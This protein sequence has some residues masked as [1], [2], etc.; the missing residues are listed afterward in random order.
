MI[1]DRYIY[2]YIYNLP[3]LLNTRSFLDNTNQRGIKETKKKKR[4]KKGI[5]SLLIGKK[6][7]KRRVRDT[8]LR[9][10]QLKSMPN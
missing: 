10:K 2:I 9:A 1:V 5:A 6:K 3:A 8:V 4:K 7:S